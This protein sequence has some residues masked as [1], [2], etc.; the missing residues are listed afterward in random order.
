MNEKNAVEVLIEIKEICDKLNI[1]FWLESGTLLG[2]Y[3]EGRFLTWDSDIDLGTSDSKLDELPMISSEFSK[4][5]FASYYSKY[6]NILALYKNGISIDFN[7]KRIEG[8]YAIMP[9]RYINNI[10][11]KILY[12]TDWIILSNV[13]GTV[14]DSI[15][16]GVKFPRMRYYLVKFANYFPT[17]VRIQIVKFL[18]IIAIKTGNARGLVK[19]PKEFCLDLQ[20][21]TFYNVNFKMPKNIEGYL[22]YYFGKE[23][24]NPDPKWTVYLSQTEKIREKWIYKISN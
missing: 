9:L 21:I 13:T 7:F 20:D 23:W 3:R 1:V 16:N 11:G 2:A 15:N 5:G 22:I 14:S 4:R 19:V 24:K 18:N 8:Q 12:F 6:N 10:I 17:S